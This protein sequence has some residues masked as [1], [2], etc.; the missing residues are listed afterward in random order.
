MS[1]TEAQTP[2]EVISLVS[3]VVTRVID[4]IAGDR[5]EVPLMVA[6]AVKEALS[7]LGITAQVMYGPAA[8]IEILEDQTPIWAG[9]WGSN[10]H[11]WTA[12][13]FGEVVDLA[14]SGAHRKRAHDSPEQ[15]AMYSPPMLW[16]KEVPGFYRYVPEGIAEL[17]ITDAEDL[18]KFE[19]VLAEVREKC[20]PEA[21]AKEKANPVFPNEAMVCPGRRVLDDTAQVFRNYDRALRVKGIPQ[22]PELSVS[23]N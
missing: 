20:T 23:G 18:R 9:C 11:F 12:T 7:G 22:A 4:R 2:V 14:V 5:V 15:K 3:R 17:E 10:F 16:A 1:E 8:W 19:L 6:S 13:H 21:V